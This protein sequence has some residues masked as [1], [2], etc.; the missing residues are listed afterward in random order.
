MNER[1]Q[2]IIIFFDGICHL[3]NGFVDWLSTVDGKAHRQFYFAP[4]QGATAK[5]FL[6]EAD[7]ASLESVIVK[8]PDGELL[9]RSDAILFCF[10]KLKGWPQMLSVFR[11][12]PRFVRDGVYLAI[13]KYR[14]RIWGQQESCRLPTPGE[15]DFLLP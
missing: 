10:S 7:R 9:R 6:S 14:Y 13:A 11:Y 3:C 8:T 12:L 5:H 2:T 4:L 15:S 1:P